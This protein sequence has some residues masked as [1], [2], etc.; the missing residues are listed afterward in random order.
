VR[1]EFAGGGTVVVAESTTSVGGSGVNVSVGGGVRVIVEVAEAG[2]AW[3][4]VG[5]GVLISPDG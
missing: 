1:E 5:S 4:K 2:G 3:V